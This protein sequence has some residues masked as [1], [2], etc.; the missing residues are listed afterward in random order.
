MHFILRLAHVKLVEN[1]VF[2]ALSENLGAW[3]VNSAGFVFFKSISKKSRGFFQKKN[4]EK[5]NNSKDTR[6]NAKIT[7]SVASTHLGQAVD[8]YFAYVYSPTKNFILEKPVFEISRF[9]N[10]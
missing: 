4:Q 3:G 2:D 1:S 9:R 6:E 8:P 10:I 5:M 7:R